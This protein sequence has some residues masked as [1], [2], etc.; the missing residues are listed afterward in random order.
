MIETGEEERLRTILG[1]IS[2]Q[3]RLT[4]FEWGLTRGLTKA[5][6]PASP[7][8][9]TAQPLNALKRQDNL[10]LDGVFLLKNFARYLRDPMVARTIPLFHSHREDLDRLRASAQGRFVP[11]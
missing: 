7:N 2:N 6:P 8:G 1:S 3:A 11:V 5:D 10:I 4:F 9:T